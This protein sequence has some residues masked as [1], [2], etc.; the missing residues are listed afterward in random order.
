MVQDLPS[1]L[2][3]VFEPGSSFRNDE[4][5]LVIEDLY[6]PRG[7]CCE[8]GKF[9]VEKC[10]G[11]W[12]QC[13]QWGIKDITPWLKL[14]NH[15]Y[16]FPTATEHR[17][18]CVYSPNKRLCDLPPSCTQR[19]PHRTKFNITDIDASNLCGPH[20]VVEK[21]G[22]E[23]AARKKLLKERNANRTILHMAT[24]DGVENLQA[25]EHELQLLL[26]EVIRLRKRIKTSRYHLKKF[27]QLDAM[28]NSILAHAER[29]RD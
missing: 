6:T 20:D 16:T 13:T 8:Y 29:T 18:R 12:Y 11:W 22:P 3:K 27:S 23:S 26:T 1:A 15:G 24:E 25:A 28:D 19:T 5:H 14:G 9:E 21:L 4:V 17:G 7:S 2:D 10:Y